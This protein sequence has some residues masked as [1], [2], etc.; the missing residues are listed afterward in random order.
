[1]VYNQVFR[2]NVDLAQAGT[3]CQAGDEINV[4]LKKETPERGHNF[5]MVSLFFV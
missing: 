1:M 3:V 5:G 2:R 4:A